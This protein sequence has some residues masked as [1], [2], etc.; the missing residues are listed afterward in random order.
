MPFGSHILCLLQIS[1]TVGVN[2]VLPKETENIL[3]EYGSKF[4]KQMEKVSQNNFSVSS[5]M[6]VLFKLPPAVP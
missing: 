5:L 4:L 6:S 2:W 1:A 3:R